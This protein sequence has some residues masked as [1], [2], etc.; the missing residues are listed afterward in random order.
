MEQTSSFVHE[1]SE[2]ELEGRLLFSALD[3]EG[4][5]AIPAH[6]LFNALQNVG[7]RIDDPRLQLSEL[8][9]T[10]SRDVH[11]T[12]I[13]P[14][15]FLRFLFTSRGTMIRDALQDRLVIP[16]FKKFREELEQIFAET[17]KNTDGH[18]ADYI[19]QLSRVDPKMFGASLCSIDGQRISL[20]NA[21]TNFCIQSVCKPINYCIALEQHG[22]DIVHRHVGREPSG[23]GFN[24]LT[25]N[26]KGLPHNPLLN[27]GAIMVCSLIHPGKEMA[28]RFDG[29]I[30]TWRRLGG[31]GNV[32]FNNA[33]YLSERQTAD[34]NFA[35]GYFMRE[36]KAFPPNTN[37]IDTLEFY[38]QCCSVE[39][40]TDVMSVVAATLANGGICPLTGERILEND[41]VKN[42]LSMMSSCGMYDFSG[43]FSFIIGLPAK[44][45]VGGGLMIVVPN[46]MGIA[47]WSPA[48]D[49]LGNSVRGIEFCKR[50]IEKYNFHVFDSLTSSSSKKRDPR[51][52]NLLLQV[53]NV[54]AL[55]SA[56]ASGDVREIQH[57]L[58]RGV[59]I[60]AADYDGRTAIHLAAS[61]GHANVVRMLILH[62]ANVNPRDRWGNTPLGD[63]KRGAHDVVIETLESNQ[64][65]V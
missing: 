31:G 46:L 39:T 37:L 25:L 21:D 28:D 22:A 42:C 9:I 50:L 41:T 57:L 15:A 3:L 34:R 53:S 33:V 1:V 59:D 62:G 56:S 20:G 6:H 2:M 14:D 36:K 23:V 40:S 5:G 43:E 47:I 58:A 32:G 65:V 35:L 60:N 12:T 11:S 30:E 24:S 64:A 55:C 61:E 7:I 38:F 49:E 18:V 16:D 48:L 63:A 19:P 29:V 44:S 52:K 45:G 27:A 13:T 54:S 4:V 10:D 8:G 17:S 26:S 51:L